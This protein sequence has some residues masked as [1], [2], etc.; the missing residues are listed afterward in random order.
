M[1]CYY[2][3]IKW[4][5]QITL[6]KCECPVFLLTAQPSENRRLQDANERFHFDTVDF[7]TSKKNL[8]LK[9]AANKI[10]NKIVVWE[11]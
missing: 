8:L 11:L 3:K 7:F 4:F 2:W 9:A 1:V 10:E 6:H 5:L